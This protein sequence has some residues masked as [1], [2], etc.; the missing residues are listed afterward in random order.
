MKTNLLITMMFLVGL[1]SCNSDQVLFSNE[2]E[3][4]GI[5]AEV[6]L[7]AA[8]LKSGEVG[9]Q[10]ISGPHV[11][12][13]LHKNQEVG[14]MFVKNDNT[15]LKVRFLNDL[16]HPIDR[17]QLWAGT[18]LSKVP[19]TPIG[20]PI[21]GKFPFKDNGYNDFTFNIP[22]DLISDDNP[23]E[24]GD[25]IKLLAHVEYTNLQNGDKE[26]AWSEGEI[27]TS[28]SNATYSDYLPSQGIGGPGCFPFT[29][30][31]G[32]GVN[33]EFYF[34]VSGDIQQDI[35]AKIGQH[36]WAKI[37]TIV[38]DFGELIFNFDQDWMFSGEMPEL[39]VTGYYELGNDGFEI[40]AGPPSFPIPPIYY[41]WDLAGDFNYYK[42]ELQVQYCY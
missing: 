35:V 32:L 41:Y 2:I 17:V 14:V 3:L 40:Y 25:L 24:N 42:I 23:L 34:N 18:E 26:S 39:L 37:G 5:A 10:S 27:L 31:C 36:S 20:Q 21:P 28:K 38:N 7:E 33:S 4:Q 1:W 8:G 30:N 6:N 11:I 16:N 13:L 29:A 22:Q 12:T 9:I 19:C 15:N